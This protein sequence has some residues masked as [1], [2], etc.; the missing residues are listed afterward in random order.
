LVERD[1]R[2]RIDAE[3]SRRVFPLAQRSGSDR[4]PVDRA[5]HVVFAREGGE[6]SRVGN[7]AHRANE[8]A[9]QPGEIRACGRRRRFERVQHHGLAFGE[10]RFDDI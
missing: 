8:A 1:G 2:N 3:N 10:Q 7:V 9:R 4:R 5:A 6:A